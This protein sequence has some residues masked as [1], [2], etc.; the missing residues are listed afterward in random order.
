MNAKVLALLIGLSLLTPF[1]RSALAQRNQP[2]Y[3]VYDGYVE[4]PDG[5]YTLSFAYFS[6]NAE[7]VTIPPG[8]ANQFAQAPADR[9]QPTVFRPGHWRFQCVMVV[10]PEFDGKMTWSLTYGGTT[11]GSS[12]KMLQSNWNLVEGAEEIQ[13][14]V[15]PTA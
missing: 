7:M 2:I 15:G 3:P 14:W 9:M 4:N 10:G 11:T 5:S 1:V 12:E 13:Y 8:T 6:H